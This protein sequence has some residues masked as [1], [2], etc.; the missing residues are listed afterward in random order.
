MRPMRT[1]FDHR[2]PPAH[3][4]WL[5][6]VAK[7]EKFDPRVARAE[8]FDQLP[9]D[10]RPDQID[11][12][13]YRN[14]QLTLL[15]RRLVTPEHPVL[16]NSEA[17]ALAVRD[18]IRRSPGIDEI[19]LPRISELTGLSKLEVQAALDA[20]NDVINLFTGW[21]SRTSSERPT[22]FFLTGPNGYDC[23]LGF[24]TLDAAMEETYRRQASIFDGDQISSRY[25]A[26]ENVQ[27]QAGDAVRRVTLKRATAFVIM[28]MD[29]AHPELVD[30]LETIRTVCAKFGIVA[31]RADEIQHQD[32]I[33]NIILNEIRSCEYLIA[34]LTYERPNVYYEIG[35]AHALE[36]KPILY[37]RLGTPLHF[38]LAVHNVPEYKNNSELA[39]LL[40]KRFEAILGRSAA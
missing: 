26:M 28:A 39:Q 20:L 8:L 33:T 5:E 38:D 16:R 37:R 24:T 30:V 3:R 6:H 31:H 1:L 12:R 29:P 21:T 19:T 15:G 2:F 7:V 22:T 27:E 4:I 10:F 34:D 9:S 35:Y 23:P 25:E 32:Q 14:G 40:K 36:K 17:V 11:T 18:E 13:F